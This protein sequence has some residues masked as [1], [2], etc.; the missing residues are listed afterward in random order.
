MS[1]SNLNQAILEVIVYFDLFSYPLTSLEI[2]QNLEHKAT[3]LEVYEQ[4]LKSQWLRTRMSTDC[5]M[6]FLRGRES[7]VITRQ[8]NYR[9]SKEKIDKVRRFV[10]IARFIPWIQNIFACNSL[11][12]LHSRPESDIDLFIVVRRG[13][14]WC[15]RFFAVLVAKLF[16]R[17]H[18]THFKDAVCLSFFAVEGANME[19]VAL[20]QDDVYFRH[21]LAHLLPLYARGGKKRTHLSIGSFFERVLRAFQLRIMPARLRAM[22]NK[23]TGVVITDEFLKFHDHDRREYFQKEYERRVAAMAA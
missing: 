6:W 22:A 4:L 19:K 18:A 13:R 14:I 15:A 12:F 2:W 8:S 16:G 23:G 5:G 9:A 3:Y 20:A 10:R 11:G 21:W 17:P 1:S 7:I